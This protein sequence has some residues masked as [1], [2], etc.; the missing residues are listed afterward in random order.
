MP[1]IQLT[2]SQDEFK[3]RSIDVVHINPSI[4]EGERGGPSILGPGSAIPIVRYA[5]IF[6]ENPVITGVLDIPSELSCS[7]G[8]VDASPKGKYFYQWKLDGVDIVGENQNTLTTTNGQT[9]LNITCEVQVVN[10]LGV[11]TQTSN[12]LIPILIE[13]IS[14][15]EFEYYTVGGLGRNNEQTT[16]ESR[17]MVVQGMVNDAMVILPELEIYVITGI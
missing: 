17:L 9:G 7:E 14:M 12:T 15:L 8:V 4:M 3:I 5:P 13:P 11:D 2:Q 6:L 16:V 1:I 10:I